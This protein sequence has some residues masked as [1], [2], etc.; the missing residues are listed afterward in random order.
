[1]VN[2]YLVNFFVTKSVY[3]CNEFIVFHEYEFLCKNRDLGMLL[4]CLKIFYSSLL[5]TTLNQNLKPEIQ[6]SL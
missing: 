5:L 4:N 6:H 2:S 3:I 1:M